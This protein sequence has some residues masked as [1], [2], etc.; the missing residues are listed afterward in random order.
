MKQLILV[1]LM[2]LLLAGC[3]HTGTT[4]TPTPAP[5]AVGQEE[6]VVSGDVIEAKSFAFTT[7]TTTVKPGAT[8]TF[9]NSDTAGHSVTGD[10]GTSFD[11]NI[12][13]SNKTTTFTAPTT[14]GSYPFHCV[15]HP[16]MKGT[17]IVQ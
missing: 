3:S 10:D 1:G 7:A 2:G 6:T 15:A 16:S 13:G 11:T 17:L 8:I 14:P 12:I 4:P 5:A 9:K